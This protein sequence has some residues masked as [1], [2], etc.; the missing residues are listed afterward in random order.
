MDLITISD[1]HPSLHQAIISILSYKHIYIPWRVGSLKYNVI[2]TD[3]CILPTL[4]RH[5]ATSSTFG[6][7]TFDKNKL[8][9]LI[10]YSIR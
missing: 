7:P 10:T 5:F 9:R 3:A 6:P 4:R 1:S 2:F 8:I